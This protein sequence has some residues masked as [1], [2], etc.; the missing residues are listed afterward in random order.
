MILGFVPPTDAYDDAAGEAIQAMGY[1][2]VASSWYAEPAEMFYV[3]DSGLMHIP[4]SQIA[5][6]NGAATW[7]DCQATDRNGVDSHSGVDCDDASVCAPSRDGKDYSDWEAY[8]EVSLADRCRN[9]FTRYGVCSILYELASY[10]GD[11][12]TGE[13]DPRAFAAY[14]QTLT[15]LE[16]LSE[17]TGAVF[18]TLGDYAAARR[19]ED[20]DAPSITIRQPVA[21]E[22]GYD[23]TLTL[24]FE[25]TDAVSGVHRVEALLDGEPVTD[26]QEVVLDDLPLGEHT[27][28]VT[29]EDVAANG[30]TRTVTFEVVDRIAPEVTIVSP[31]ATTYAHHQSAVVDVDV[32]DAKSEVVRT[33]I[34]LDGASL[35]DGETIDMLALDL[36]AHTLTVVAEDAAGNVAEEEVT[37]EV[38]ATLASLVAVVERLADEGAI[39][40][41]GVERSLLLKLRAAQEALARDQVHVAV[42]NLVAVEQQVSALTSRQ[43]G[44]AAA[45][46]LVEDAAAVRERLEG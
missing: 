35:T 4:W 45:G 3:D 14:K 11:F 26:G 7:T 2:W 30:A 32:A 44:E 36:G 15:E 1:D 23:E 41:P 6:G 20:L 25:V 5:C 33:E 10:D 22:V 17:E 13:L 9:D 12:A 31:E 21:G 39:A 40:D 43:I 8:A 42:R 38:E 16:A 24:D 34:Q 28:T 29:A 37:F 46:T 19:A 27:L 18:M